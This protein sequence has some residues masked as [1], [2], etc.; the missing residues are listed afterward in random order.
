MEAELGD[1][2]YKAL[3]VMGF[4]LV[5]MLGLGWLGRKRRKEE[6]LRDFYLAGSSFG[7]FVLFLTL[8]ATQY[9]G[10]TLLG[11][12]G[13]S[14]NR[15][16]VYIVSITFMILVITVFMIYAPRLFRLSRKFGYITPADYVFHRFGSH[17]IRI[18]TVILLAWGLSNYILEQL[19]AMGHGVEALSGGKITS[20]I[21]AT[22]ERL[23]MGAMVAGAE[24]GQFDFM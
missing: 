4:Y 14:Y 16:G 17:P 22:M 9:S 1:L 8:F 18:L 20:M 15:G 24:P 5:V 3:V 2:G 13:R 21:V 6:S 11:F 23:G 19:V 10:N 12:A 7:F